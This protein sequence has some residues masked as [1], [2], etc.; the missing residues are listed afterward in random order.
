VLQGMNRPDAFILNRMAILAS[1]IGDHQRA[2]KLYREAAAA[3]PHLGAPLFNLAL[4]LE[5]HGDLGGAMEAADEAVSREP[6]PPSLVLRAT[7]AEKRGDAA[8]RERDLHA[9][10]ET[11]LPPRRLNDWALGWLI[12]AARMAGDA[13]LE[14]KARAELKLRRKGGEP[15]E[16]GGVLPSLRHLEI[17]RE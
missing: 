1:E 11:F 3:A 17:V 13:E 4:L 6:E 2:E 9:A 7:L 16:E 8:A 14:E 5:H 12:T 10:L 15:V